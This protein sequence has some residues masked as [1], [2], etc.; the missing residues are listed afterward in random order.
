[1][2]APFV[3]GL[4]E[5]PL[6]GDGAMGTMLYARGVPLDTCF[7]V[8]NESDPKIVQS[9]HTEYIQAGADCIETNTFGANRFKLAMHGSAGRV[10]EINRSGARL[11]RDVRE[12]MG[13]DVFVLG[14]IGPL[15][16][17]LAP[18]GSV[19]PDEARAAFFEQAE[20]LLEGGVDAFIV[21][22]FSD[23]VEM[24]QAV[25]AIRAL[26]DLPIVAQV[27]FTDD[28]VTFFGRAPAAVVRA[29]R[30]AQDLLAEDP[31]RATAIG[32]R[33]FEPEHLP[34]IAELIRRDLPYYDAA[35]PE[36]AVAGMNRFARER[37]LLEGDPAYES[38]VA[39]ELAPLWRD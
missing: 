23:P 29:L 28:G 32:E 16:R 9:I 34:L 26:T 18:L 4:L 20:G 15:G 19:E 10:R 37:G 1:M 33:I 3:A 5:R 8:L 38:V 22:T 35:I 13:R 24:Q 21:E 6:L 30:R 11:A 7:D 2:P 25:L 36:R 39:T 27:A 12:S 17:Y 31:G 14:S